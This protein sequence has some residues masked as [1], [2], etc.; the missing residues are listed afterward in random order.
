MYRIKNWFMHWGKKRKNPKTLVINTNIDLDEHKMCYYRM[1]SNI[2][3]DTKYSIDVL[4]TYYRHFHQNEEKETEQFIDR[5]RTIKTDVVCKLQFGAKERKEIIDLLETDNYYAMNTHKRNVIMKVYKVKRPV[6]CN[7]TRDYI[8]KVYLYDTLSP[9]ETVASIQSGVPNE[10]TFQ[11]Y[12]YE[13]NKECG[14]ISPIIESYGFIRNIS[15]LKAY[16]WNPE[17]T[18]HCYY[19]I[20][21]YLQGQNYANMYQDVKIERDVE[22][23]SNRLKKRLLYH[24]D[25]N[26]SNIIVMEHTIGI[27]D[28]GES[29]YMPHTL[30]S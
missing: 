11:K 16:Y 3:K 8:I 23:V 21:E 27:I 4:R 13:L 15:K 1:L 26:R 5:I 29:D 9:P 22:I 24:N 12:A 14:F 2:E 10:I 7:K 20:M 19:I 6:P 25:L 30:N 28:Y 18:V 17:A